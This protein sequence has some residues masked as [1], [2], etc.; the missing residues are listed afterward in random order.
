MEATM[1]TKPH[2]T[3]A[4]PGLNPMPGGQKPRAAMRSAKP[5]V[6]Q[7]ATQRTSGDSRAARGPE[8][9]PD[10]EMEVEVDPPGRKGPKSR[11]NPET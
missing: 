4:N 3:G 10:S 2:D 11:T 5:I 1:T 6:S 8:T 7:R 9:G